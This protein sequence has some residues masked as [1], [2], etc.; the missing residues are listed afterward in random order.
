MHHH[1]VGRVESLV[2][3]IMATGAIRVRQVVADECLEFGRG[4]IILEKRSGD[5]PANSAVHVLM[6]HTD[7]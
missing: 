2:K 3:M 6:C 4:S 1:G 7:T 5:K